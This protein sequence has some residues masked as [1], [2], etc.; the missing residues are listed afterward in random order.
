MVYEF[1]ITLT[2][3]EPVTTMTSID[4]YLRGVSEQFIDIHL[5]EKELQNMSAI[6][7]IFSLGIKSKLDA[8][9]GFFLGHAYAELL[10]QFLIINNRLPDKNE[11]T[12]FFNL[13]KRRYPEIMNSLKKKRNNELLEHGEEVVSVADLNIEPIS[14]NE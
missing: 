14:L 11:T 5:N 3:V 9:I 7:D 13:L 6:V 8:N 2:L 1:I 10:M 12:N 4:P